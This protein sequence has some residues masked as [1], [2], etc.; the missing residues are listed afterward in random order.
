MRKLI[1]LCCT[2]ILST[3][4][5][6][7]ASDSIL[8]QSTTSTQS[9]GLFKYLLPVY[10]DMTGI[11]V[12]VVAVGTGQ[13][14]KNAE[15]GDADVV[16]VHSKSAEE[17]FIENG[18]GIARRPFMYNEFFVVGPSHDPAD[19]QSASSA[20]DAL[21]KISTSKSKWVSRGDMS[22]THKKEL[23]LWASIPMVPKG[24]W[25]L[26]VGSGMGRTLGMAVE[27]EGY[28]LV[29]SATWFSYK[30]KGSCKVLYQGDRSLSN[31]YSLILVNDKIHPHVKTKSATNFIEWLLSKD[32]QATIG[33]FKLNGQQLYYPNADKS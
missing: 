15:N 8:L 4:F 9:S 16:M 3:S 22:G 2:L 12:K 33:R 31:Q 23:Q 20:T 32:G 28:T 11:E 5:H 1:L 10:Q 25:Y 26:D 14:L 13:A 6:L 21:K 29:D 18:Y 27:L 7:A 30:G 19:I 24:S 17:T